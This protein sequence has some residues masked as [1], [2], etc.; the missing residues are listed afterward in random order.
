[1]REF[2]NAKTVWV[3]APS[4]EQQAGATAGSAAE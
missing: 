3:G 2:M 1:M 4:S